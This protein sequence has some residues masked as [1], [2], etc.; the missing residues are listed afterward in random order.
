MC[1]KELRC[2][3]MH[4]LAAQY[5]KNIFIQMASA[6]IEFMRRNIFMCMYI[7]CE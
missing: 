6:N 7:K 5:L 2:D 4:D 3:Y 1:K